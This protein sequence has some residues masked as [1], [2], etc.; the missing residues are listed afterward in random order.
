MGSHSVV[1]FDV[2]TSA[3]DTCWVNLKKMEIDNVDPILCDVS[4]L[5]SA[6][7]YGE[8]LLFC[9]DCCAVVL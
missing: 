4:R 8:Q 3:V 1:G 7:A 6:M 2:D 9:E 5:D